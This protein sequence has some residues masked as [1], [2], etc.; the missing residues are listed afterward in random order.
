MEKYLELLLSISNKNKYS[1]WYTSIIMRASNRKEQ[2]L[3][4]SEK[5]HILPKSFRMGGE[6]DKLN[7]VR[8]TSR[9]HFIC[10]VLLLKMVGGNLK[11]RMGRALLGMKRSPSQ[12]RYFNS[13]LYE[14]MRGHLKHSEDSKLK[15]SIA[16]KGTKATE[17]TKRTLSASQKIRHKENPFSADTRE[18]LRKINIEQN[19]QSMKIVIEGIEYFSHQHA[20]RELGVSLKNLRKIAEGK[21]STI[22]EAIQRKKPTI[23]KPM[24]GNSTKRKIVTFDGVEYS[25]IRAFAK[26]KEL[27]YT[28]ARLLIQI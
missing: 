8:L 28:K 1:R 26:S 6:K 27:S 5:H 25:S 23:T 15:M 21:C 22:E 7:L 19:P 24:G 13:R 9:E 3:G 4:Y 16:R 20:M 12:Q 17:K 18:K 10:H 14:S 2:L 11:Y